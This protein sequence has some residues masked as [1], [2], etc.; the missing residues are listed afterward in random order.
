[1]QLAKQLV[2]SQMKFLKSVLTGLIIFLILF[3]GGILTWYYLQGPEHQG[4][5]RSD[6]ADR[7]FK[8]E[9]IVE[10]KPIP[11][12]PNIIFILADD[13]GYG[14]VGYNQQTVIDTKNLDSLAEH[15][16][17]FSNFYAP[18][19][20]CTPSRFGFLSGRYALRQGL[21]YPFHHVNPG[22]IMNIGSRF[23]NFMGAVDM[24]G[25]H[26]II[27]G[28][29]PSEVI[30]PEL[31]K[32]AGYR[33]GI[34]GKWHLGTISQDA[35]FHP[36]N[37]GFDYFVGLEASNDDWPVAFY[38]NERKM[39]DDIGLDQEHYTQLFTDSAKS[40]IRQN[41]N[42]PFFLYLAHKDPHQPFFPSKGFKGKSKAGAYGDAVEEFD[43]SVGEILNLLDSLNL[44]ENT[45]VVVTS[46]NGPW[47]EGNPCGLRG[48]KGQVYEGGY[49]VPFMIRYPKKLKTAYKTNMPAMGIDLLP[50]LVAEA[51]VSIPK[52]RKIDGMNLLEL[53]NDTSETSLAYTRPLF[54][55][56][57]YAFEAVRVGNWKFME[58]NYS[59]T[60]PIPLEHPKYVTSQ[61][62]SKYSPPESDTVINRLDNWPKLYY[63]KDNSSESYNLSSRHDQKVEEMQQML[64][65][66]RNDFLTN[67]RGW[68]DKPVSDN[69]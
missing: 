5:I 22:L 63:L 48:R 58:T 44:T 49:R 32:L 25:E 64:S 59:Y 16:V 3:V 57:D 33:T 50:T 20:I 23:A 28:I 65:E 39:L 60:W 30:I 10:V 37:H 47:F 54:F 41:Q 62:V 1:M 56:H 7:P 55:F 21:A 38:E 29:M 45:I 68:L 17:V 27:N 42:Q 2:H 31:L 34:V 51:G 67:P 13:L 46:D 35:Q 66:F 61:Y 40:F 11:D 36:F 12:K 69:H 24:R 15:S 4:L 14:D 19:S 52:D 18:A 26:N 8:L 9:E 43:H 6:F 53:L